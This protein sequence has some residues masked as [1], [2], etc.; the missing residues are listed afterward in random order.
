[1]LLV[2]DT[3]MGTVVLAERREGVMHWTVGS[4]G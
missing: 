1:M 3:G 4:S 2:R